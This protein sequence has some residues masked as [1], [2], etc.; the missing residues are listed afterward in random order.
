MSN[1]T[2]FA[3]VANRENELMKKILGLI[4]NSTWPRPYFC[5]CSDLVPLGVGSTDQPHS[6]E[7]PAAV[8]KYNIGDSQAGLGP[9]GS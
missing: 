6:G 2:F 4:S 9:D 3:Y 8:K 7:L 5:G 1:C